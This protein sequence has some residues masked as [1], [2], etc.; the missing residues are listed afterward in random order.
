MFAQSR[1]GDFSVFA[2]K[3]PSIM[4]EDFRMGRLIALGLSAMLV[5]LG[6]TMIAVALTSSRSIPSVPR[7]TVL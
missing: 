3:L 4:N 1:L 6:S 2:G 7:M 5:P